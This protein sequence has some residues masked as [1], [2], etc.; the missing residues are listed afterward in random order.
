[1]QGRWQIISRNPLTI[2]DTGH[3]EA[4][5]QEVVGQ[6]KK[7]PHKNLHIVFGVV[8]DKDPSL[9]LQHLPKKATYY[10]CKAKLPRAMDQAELAQLAG[11]FNL[12]G[13]SYPSVRQALKA[14]QAKASK[15]DL[16]FVGG[17]TFVVA[18]VI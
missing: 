7:T 11:K 18:E 13:N 8:N 16:I 15:G 4:G 1:L 14:A 12:K 3:N 10:F 9:V 17:S 2:A 6:L 5:I